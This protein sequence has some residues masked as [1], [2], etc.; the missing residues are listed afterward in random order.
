MFYY[1]NGNIFIHIKLITFNKVGVIIMKCLTR[2]KE[3]LF[4]FKNGVKIIGKND[5]MIGN[6][7]GLKGD[8]DLI[9]LE[10]R[11]KDCNISSYVKED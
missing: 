11:E 7:T 3:N 8:L 6:C 10:E 4:Y 9:T 5:L 2:N 1:T